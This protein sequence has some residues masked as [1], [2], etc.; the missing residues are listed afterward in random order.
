MIYKLF[1]SLINVTHLAEDNLDTSFQEQHK[2]NDA[3]YNSSNQSP[4]QTISNKTKQNGCAER[5]KVDPCGNLL[6]AWA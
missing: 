6:K 4:I 3:K 1:N 2:I 5:H